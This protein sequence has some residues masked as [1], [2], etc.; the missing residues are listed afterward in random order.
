MV[1]R[2]AGPLLRPKVVSRFHDGV[3]HAGAPPPLARNTSTSAT[4]RRH[5]TQAAAKPTRP[6]GASPNR[7]QIK[8]ASDPSN[9]AFD[10]VLHPEIVKVRARPASIPAGNTRRFPDAGQS[11]AAPASPPA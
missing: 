10:D 1:C 7:P 3:A 11:F 6:R 2:A 5:P 8:F 9:A 4:K